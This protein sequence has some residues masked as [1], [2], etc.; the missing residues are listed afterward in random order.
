MRLSEE[1]K[2]IFI[3]E[4][5]AGEEFIF[6]HIKNNMK[7]C[8]EN[9]IHLRPVLDYDDG[10]LYLCEHCYLNNRRPSFN[11]FLYISIQ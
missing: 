8:V 10:V 1:A 4:E 7:D 9:K 11:S 3:N 5:N 6:A 2:K